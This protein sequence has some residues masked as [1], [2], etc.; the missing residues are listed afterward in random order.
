M[1]DFGIGVCLRQTPSIRRWRIAKETAASMPQ[2][3]GTLRGN[4]TTK[5]KKP[6]KFYSKVWFN[7]P[8]LAPA[9]ITQCLQKFGIKPDGTMNIANC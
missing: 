2:V 4:F 9:R 3:P 6:N 8:G 5:S 1:P 7:T